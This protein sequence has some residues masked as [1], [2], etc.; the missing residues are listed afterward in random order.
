LDIASSITAWSSMASRPNAAADP[1][2]SRWRAYV[3]IAGLALL[4]LT[5]VPLHLIA[6][7]GGRSSPW[8]CRF[9]GRA[10]YIAG[11]RVQI[12]GAPLAPHSLVLANH[13]SWL[14]ILILGGAGTRFVSKAEIGR[15]PL[16]GWLSDQNDTLYIERSERG[17]AHGQVR[18]IAEALRAPQPLTVFPEGT[19]GDGSTLLPFRSTLL[20]AVAPPPP[21]VSVRPVALDYTDSAAIAWHGEESGL[22]NALRVVGMKGHRRVTVRLLDALAPTNDRKALARSAHAAVL[23]ALPSV[24]PRD[25]LE[26]APND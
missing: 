24:A 9:L 5:H 26:A 19:T 18:R 14:D 10:A 11:A 20:H 12:D 13:T 2:S 1:V 15:V 21:G 3:R 25:P 6:K 7:R 23:A 16:I 17:D 8:P 4:A 22:A